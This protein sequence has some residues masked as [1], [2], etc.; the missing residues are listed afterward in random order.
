MMNNHR[1]THKPK[2]IICDI[3]RK[4]FSHRHRLSVHKKSHDA[5]GKH[6]C[7]FDDARFKT[8][9][10]LHVHYVAKHVEY[11][12]K[13]GWLMHTCEH[14]GKQL[15]TKDRYHQHV[16]THTG[17]KPFKCTMCEKRFAINGNL[18]AH[19]KIHKN[20][21]PFRCSYCNKRFM[22]KGTFKRHILIHEKMSNSQ[23]NKNIEEKI[24]HKYKTYTKDP[25]LAISFIVA[26]TENYVTVSQEE[27]TTQTQ[28][29]STTNGDYVLLLPANHL[30]QAPNQSTKY[31]SLL[32]VK[33]TDN[34]VSVTSV[35]HSDHDYLAPELAPVEPVPE[36]NVSTTKSDLS[37]HVMSTDQQGLIE[38][39]P[40][41]QDVD[42]L[43]QAPEVL[44]QNTEQV[45]ISSTFRTSS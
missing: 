6:K 9:S 21:R 16:R 17:E 10:N 15:A 14:C 43:E 23:Q 37:M 7:L 44:D 29:F 30:Q 40:I 24:S 41:V 35:P 20:D 31:K 27:A 32:P 18:I 2:T 26:R 36:V 13:R 8:A 22:H 12:K 33:I 45:M 28:T 42:V 11:A 38:P 4:V 19:M 5:I 3:C 1:I 34:H 39:A 25:L